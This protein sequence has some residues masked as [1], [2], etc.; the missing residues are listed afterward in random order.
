MPS[1]RPGIPGRERSPSVPANC[2]ANRFLI[3]DR[4]SIFSKELEDAIAMGVRVLRTPI[5]APKANSMCERFGGTLRRECL[6]FF[7]PFNERQLRSIVKTWV[8]LQP[9]DAA[10]EPWSGDPCGI[11]PNGATEWSSASHSCE[12]CGSKCRGSGGLHHEYWLEKIAACGFGWAFC[13]AQGTNGLVGETIAA[14]DVR[15]P[16]QARGH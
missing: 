5:R 11:T 13:G 1:G 16:H 3:L 9:R 15:P 12:P 10:H 6:D 2:R 14:C 7:I 4:D 8:A